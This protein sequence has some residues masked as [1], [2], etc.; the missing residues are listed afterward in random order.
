MTKSYDDITLKIQ[1]QSVDGNVLLQDDGRPCEAEAPDLPQPE[2][3]QKGPRGGMV[4]KTPD[5]VGVIAAAEV[6]NPQ[7]LARHQKRA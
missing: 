3:Q 5:G 6:S 2:N 4:I 1:V 7:Q